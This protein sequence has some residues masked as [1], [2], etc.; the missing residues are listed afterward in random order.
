MSNNPVA[1]VLG[2]RGA[3]AYVP[4]GGGFNR[5]EFFGLDDGETEVIRLLTDFEAVRASD[6][7]LAG[8]W[9]AFR[10]HQNIPTKPAPSDYKGKWPATMPANCRRDP[11]FADAYSDCYI[12]D[13]IGPMLQYYKKP[14]Q[15]YFALAVL[16]EA[17]KEDGRIVGYKDKTV[18]VTIKGKDGEEDRVEKVK[19]IVVVNMAWKNFFSILNGYASAY[20][21]VLDRDYQ[22]TRHGEKLDTTYTVI[23]LDPIHANLDGESVPFDLRDDRLMV[24][25]LPRAAEIGYAKAS[26]ERLSEV[27][28]ERA[29]DDFYA[30]FFDATK[31]VPTQSSG[32][33]TGGATEAQSTNGSVPTQTVSP[34]EVTVD[35]SVNRL[36]D[37][38]KGAGATA[39]TPQAEESAPAQAPVAAGVRSFD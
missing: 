8:G 6:G 21:T 12:C 2:K 18:E 27:I 33:G 3:E 36:V 35:A 9:P 22:I 20:G 14:G 19:A 34:D 1:P 31:S 7:E 23:P 15:R 29:S 5:T 4:G 24:R 11:Q 16:R 13:V 30:R 37:R 39:Y 25:Y 10:Q 17:V 32:G 38:I 26:D 28:A